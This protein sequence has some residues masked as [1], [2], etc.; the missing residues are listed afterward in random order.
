[1][2]ELRPGWNRPKPDLISAPTVWPAGL[3]LGT[4][5]LAWGLVASAIIL[6]FGLALFAISLGG[7][8]G[9]LRHE[10]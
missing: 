9:E 1:M 2:S 4:M 10:P 5:F 6:V 8:I 7:W 3:A